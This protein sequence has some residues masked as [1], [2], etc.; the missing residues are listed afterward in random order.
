MQFPAKILFTTRDHHLVLDFGFLQRPLLHCAL[1]S[2]LSLLLLSCGPDQ[3][4]RVL[5][6]PFSPIGPSTDPDAKG[7]AQNPD[8]KGRSHSPWFAPYNPDLEARFKSFEVQCKENCPASIA[9]LV[10][11]LG[12]QP[13]GQTDFKVCGAAVFEKDN[14]VVT[15]RHCLPMDTIS[16]GMSCEDKVHFIFPAT[17]TLPAK[18]IPC[19]EIVDFS[20]RGVITNQNAQRYGDWAILKLAKPVPQRIVKVNREGLRDNEPLFL[21]KPFYQSDK[22]LVEILK[23]PCRHYDRTIA[24]PGEDHHFSPMGLVRCETKLLS[25]G[26]SGYAF[27]NGYNEIMG[28]QSQNLFHANDTLQA[29]SKTG[30]LMNSS[31][32]SPLP[33]SPEA[34]R[35]CAISDERLSS[36]RMRRR[37]RFF[38]ERASLN[39]RWVRDWLR[40]HPQHPIEWADIELKKIE[41]LPTNWRKGFGNKNQP[42]CT[43]SDWQDHPLPFPETLRRKRPQTTAQSQKK[44]IQP[45]QLKSAPTDARVRK[46]AQSHTDS[47]KPNQPPSVSGGSVECEWDRLWQRELKTSGGLDTQALAQLSGTER[48]KAKAQLRQQFEDWRTDVFLKP[49][50]ERT[51]NLF[52]APLIPSCVY[53][54]KWDQLTSNRTR[55]RSVSIEVPIVHGQ[56]GVQHKTKQIIARP[57]GLEDITSAQA[58]LTYSEQNKLYRLTLTGAGRNRRKAMD[59]T[60]TKKADTIAKGGFFQ[61]LD[62]PPCP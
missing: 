35:Y 11:E 8:E 21:F 56:V 31:C 43:S 46:V 38:K 45:K 59:E 49:H 47:Q 42:K 30:L 2:V 60:D 1:L 23:I 28:I 53:K 41:S 33:D 10:A 37:A 13:N 52:Y 16:K 55:R 25:P 7:Y 34:R 3:E 9:T 17:D 44:K 4:S 27:Y 32:M 19:E 24:V 54:D 36:K 40:S 20:H 51:R 15:A 29:H 58:T 6:T 26:Y 5:S 62:I 12:T 50:L 39:R 48:Q 22:S 18:V 57:N 61:A 14:W